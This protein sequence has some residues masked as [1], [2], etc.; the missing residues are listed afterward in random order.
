M[1][2][3]DFRI[4][5]TGF[6]IGEIGVMIESLAPASRGKKDPADTIPES[7]TKPQ[8]AKASELWVL[9]RH[10]LYCGNARND[11]VYSVLM[12]SQPAAAVF[13]S[14]PY[15]NLVDG[16]V[17]GFGENHHVKFA[18]VEMS[19]AEFESFLTE[20]LS[21]LARHSADG[22]LQFICINWRYTQELLAAAQQVNMEFKDLCI[23]VANVTREGSLY[24]NQHELV[25]VFKAGKGANTNAQLGQSGR[26]RSN[27][28]K[29]RRVNS[30]SRH[31]GRKKSIGPAPHH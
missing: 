1:F 29:Y 18:P 7:A 14:P 23:W 11:A 17:A 2:E 31:L 28:W 12:Q 13:S 30:V 26:D 16:S 22:A 5:V 20:V 10:R 8:V 9:N 27:V 4:D 19:K 6:E 24:R 15:N 3:L 21:L 25:F